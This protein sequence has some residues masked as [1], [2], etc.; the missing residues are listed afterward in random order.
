M[1]K[2]HAQTFLSVVLCFTFLD[3]DQPWTVSQS[4][5]ELN[6]WIEAK[7][8]S[9][10]RR[11][12]SSTRSVVSVTGKHTQV[13]VHLKNRRI[14]ISRIVHHRKHEQHYNESWEKKTRRLNYV[15]IDSISHNQI[16]Y[17]SNTHKN[18]PVKLIA[19]RNNNRIKGTQ[20]L[21]KMFTYKN[22]NCAF[23]PV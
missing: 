6:P 19:S 20:I 15:H 13:T 5:F 12:T 17:S 9:F 11:P 14:S 4:S 16:H 1:S 8:A 7:S 21:N 2:L 22:G 18:T 23:N 3:C 10:I